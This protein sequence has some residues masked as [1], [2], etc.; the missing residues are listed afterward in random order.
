MPIRQVQH[1]IEIPAFMPCVEIG[2]RTRIVLDPVV[3]HQPNIGVAHDI[4][5]CH[6]DAM[7]FFLLVSGEVLPETVL[8]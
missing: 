8:G 4:L 1:L 2:K 3:A 7:V 6:F 5:A